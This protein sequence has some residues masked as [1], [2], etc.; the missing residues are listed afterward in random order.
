[1]PPKATLF[2]NGSFHAHAHDT[3]KKEAVAAFHGRILYVGD[4]DVARNVFPKGIEPEVIDLGGKAAIPGFTDSHLH[5]MSLG[6]GFRH[7]RLDDVTSIAELKARVKARAGT[8]GPGEW[9]L[10]RGWDQDYFRERRYPTRKD[11]DE[12]AGDRPVYLTRGC[13]HL[14]VLSSKALEVA[15][16]TRDTPDPPGGVIDRDMYG[17]PT[18]VL[19]ESAQ[20]LA[21]DKVPQPSREALEDSTKEAMKHLLSKGITTIHPN[22]GHAGFQGTMEV[23][24]NAHADGIPLRVYWDMPFDF[25]PELADTPLRTGDG[26]DYLRIG[27]VKIFADGSLGGRTAALEE[28]YSDD[29]RNSGILVIPEETLKEHVYAAHVLGMQVA[30]HAIGDKA[31]RLSIEA[32][33]EAQSRLPRKPLRHRLVHVQILSAFL[34]T[35]MRRVGVVAD[36]QPKFL[37]TDM[38]WAQ[39]RVGTQRMRSSYS[40]HTMLKAGI[41]LAGG[42]DCPV[43]PADPLFGIYAAVTRK[44]MDGNPKGAFYPNERVT[45][46]EAVRMFTLGGSYAAFQEDQKGTLEPG[47]LADFVVLSEDLFRVAPDDIKDLEVLMTVVGGEV[48]YKKP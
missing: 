16:I 24:R 13:G 33:A 48:A 38:R 2:V 31:T 32:I 27:A 21:R 39:D 20:G 29:P 9:V 10:G 42:S 30:V 44:D 35:E 26:D 11:L 17:E 25:L 14:A 8:A 15:G 45:L 37:T 7:I 47:K 23:Y 6:L 3:R 19:R 36:V 46:E 34:I 12:A 40:W 28:P 41:P 4:R 43:E 1:M 5:L 22:D 18:G